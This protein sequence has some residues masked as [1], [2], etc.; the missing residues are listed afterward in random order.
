M[1]LLLVGSRFLPYRHEG[2]KNFWLDLV[3][4]IKAQTNEIHILS[5]CYDLEGS[6]FRERNVSIHVSRPVPFPTMGSKFTDAKLRASNSQASRWLS[7]LKATG[8]L[9]RLCRKYEIDV[10]QFMENWGPVMLAL[11]VTGFRTPSCVQIGGYYPRVAGYEVTVKLLGR[12]FSSVIPSTEALRHKL[13]EIGVPRER[14]SEPIGW[15]VDVS[16]IRRDKSSRQ[17]VRRE[18]GVENDALLVLWSGYLQRTS[19]REFWYSVKVAREVLKSC[20]QCKFIFCFKPVH[21]KKEFLRFSASGLLIVKASSNMD[22]LNLVNASDIFLSPYLEEES[23]LN[24]PL[25]W[26]ECMA[27]GLPVVTTDAAG[28][29]E[30]ILKGFNGF[31]SRSREEMVQSILGLA[32]D[33]RLLRAM[34]ANARHF[35]CRRHDISD[36]AAKFVRLWEGMKR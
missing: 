1:N 32:A 19:F 7:F 4:R 10:V 36:V 18:Y 26:L 15:G 30:T 17:R 13:L 33:Q 9:G 25:T 35:V 12:N 2:D 31:A 22:F 28:L 14:I 11:P 6:R 21:F 20:H 8:K 24:V 29:R 3:E 27:S 5:L 23:I 16:R 34:S